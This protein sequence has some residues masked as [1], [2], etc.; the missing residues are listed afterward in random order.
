MVK[1]KPHGTY[2]TNYA[3]NL[4]PFSIVANTNF[5][6]E[7]LAGSCFLIFKLE[8]DAFQRYYKKGGSLTS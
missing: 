4:G 7:P 3:F 2:S 5:E 8:L 6:F 1:N